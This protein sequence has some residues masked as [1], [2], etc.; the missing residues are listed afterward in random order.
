[1][2]ASKRY[3]QGTTKLLKNGLSKNQEARSRNDIEEK[4]S[5]KKR[6]RQSV[7]SASCLREKLNCS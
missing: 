5:K 1:M 3:Q 4:V 7:N 6:G 2:N